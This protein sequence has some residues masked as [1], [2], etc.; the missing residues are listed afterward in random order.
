[1]QREEAGQG[2]DL[3]DSKS[4]SDRDDP[5]ILLWEW[6][7]DLYDPGERRLYRSGLFKRPY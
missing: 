1:M 7:G 2:V 6:D 5:D 4:R 3:R